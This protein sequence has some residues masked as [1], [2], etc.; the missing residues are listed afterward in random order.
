LGFNLLILAIPIEAL[1]FDFLSTVKKKATPTD[2]LDKI[3]KSDL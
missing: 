3:L 1:E 2:D